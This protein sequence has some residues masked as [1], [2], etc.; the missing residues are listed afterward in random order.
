MKASYLSLIV[1]S[2]F[3]LQAAKADEYQWKAGVSRAKITPEGTMWQAGYASRDQAATGVM[4]DL[5]IKV[6]A[7]EDQQG[8]QA[9]LITADIVG[10]PK[11]FTDR[12]RSQLKAAFNL[13]ASQIIINSSHSHSGPIIF[14]SLHDFYGVSFDSTQENL[15][16]AYTAKMEQHMLKATR[17]ALQS[18]TPARV[19]TGNGVT[20]FQV[21]RRNNPEASISE[22]FEIKGP[23]DPSVPVIKVA[24]LSGRLLS[25][26]FGYACHATV[27]GGYEWSG[28]Y[29]GFAQLELE[30]MYPDA[31]AMFFQ[32]AGG[33][34][35]P[36][37][38]RTVSLA[39]QYGKELA[40]AV[41]S[42]LSEEMHKQPAT[43][44]TA[45]AEIDLP[46]SAPP[47]RKKLEE[48]AA[49]NTDYTCVWAKRMLTDL[50]SQGKLNNAYPFYPVQLWKLGQQPLF[51]LGGEVVIDYAIKLK[52]MYGM[53]VF[54]MGYANDVMA[55]IPSLRVLH[56][57]GY[58]GSRSQLYFPGMSANWDP[59]IE[60]RI[61]SGMEKLAEEIGLEKAQGVSFP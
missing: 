14:D 35:N 59:S 9:L 11:S 23:V 37:P 54:V 22:L 10:I 61:M 21:N 47:D 43:L 56:E 48:L 4:H 52:Y 29:P 45:Y 33:D 16:R 32:G 38:R 55:Y 6:L 12:I 5:W 36:L 30:K 25:I 24:D 44:Q 15:I 28:D 7:L 20:R 49:H 46:L 42:V 57:G 34:Q 8:H 3:V 27:L 41:E 50:N 17:E 60:S 58:E 26:V 2:L 31:T 39:K 19:F 1:G 18:L 40:A 13:T 51:S 53:D